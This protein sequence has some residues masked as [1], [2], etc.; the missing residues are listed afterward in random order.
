VT[1]GQ[2]ILY[3][4]ALS[5]LEPDRT[6]YVAVRSQVYEDFFREPVCTMLLEN[7]RLRL[8]VFDP[9]DRAVVRWIP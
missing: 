4:D 2:F 9:D 1:L 6:L 3:G 7:G 5:R 8:V